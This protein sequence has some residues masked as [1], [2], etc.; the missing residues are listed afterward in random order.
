[1]GNAYGLRMNDDFD[2]LPTE[3]DQKGSFVANLNYLN[4]GFALGYQFIFWKRMS[5]DFVLFGPSLSFFT[6]EVTISGDQV[7][8]FRATAGG[9]GQRLCQK[10]RSAE[11]H[12]TRLPRQKAAAPSLALLIQ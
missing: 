11:D 3:I 5:L 12:E 8:Q 10:P 7:K 9:V 1:M 2:I 6:G 4:L